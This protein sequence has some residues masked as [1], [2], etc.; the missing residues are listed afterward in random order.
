[1]GLN[2]EIGLFAHLL[3]FLKQKKLKPV[4][5]I[6]TRHSQGLLCLKGNGRWM[7]TTRSGDVATEV[8]K[9]TLCPQLWDILTEHK[10]SG[11]EL[12]FLLF[13]KGKGSLYLW[14]SIVF[15]LL[16]SWISM[17]FLYQ[18]TVTKAGCSS[19][20]VAGIGFLGSN[21]TKKKDK[22][23]RLRFFH[24]TGQTVL[25]VLE[26]GQSS[27]LIWRPAIHFIYVTIKCAS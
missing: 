14:L 11:L 12:F 5:E 10:L 19:S 22:Q 16:S 25:L 27:D 26:K 9:N 23:D 18:K 21:H 1:M 7:L 4:A 3:F 13:Y 20:T 17:Y 2:G 6:F 24:V 8:L 15:N